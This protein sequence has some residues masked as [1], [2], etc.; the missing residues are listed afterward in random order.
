[1]ARRL[2]YSARYPL[3]T[4]KEVYGALANRDYWEARVEEMR[5]YSPNHVV[6]YQAD[7]S[8]IEVELNHILPRSE[9]PDIAQAFQ[10]KDMVITRKESYPAFGPDVVG[11]YEA[12][13]PAAPGSLTGSMRL[14]ETETGC[15][16]RTSSEAKVYIP[17]MGPK[18]EQMI[19]INLI[20][21]FRAEAE[22]TVGW[23]DAQHPIS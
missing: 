14:F 16:M 3:H 7:D 22:F 9:L 4:V 12:S 1:M 5:K 19:L 23:L 11:S 17:M 18:F 2:D 21:L 10:R 8:G 13:M 6:S 15:T 20:D